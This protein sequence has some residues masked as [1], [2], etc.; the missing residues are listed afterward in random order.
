[1]RFIN[2]EYDSWKYKIEKAIEQS[3][4]NKKL[5]R[6]VYDSFAPIRK[7]NNVRIMIDGEMYF[8]NIAE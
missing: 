3:P 2:K 1:M 5:P 4:W 7:P 8:R 6:F